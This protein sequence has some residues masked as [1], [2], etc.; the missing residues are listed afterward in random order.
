VAWPARL[1]CH[2]LEV[3]LT[4]KLKPSFE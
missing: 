2:C 1:C 4:C 3:L